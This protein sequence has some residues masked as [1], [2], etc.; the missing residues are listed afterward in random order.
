MVCR[1]V[2]IR[3]FLMLGMIG[4]LLALI[5]TYIG[6]LGVGAFLLGFFSFF[7]SNRFYIKVFFLLTNL[8]CVINLQVFE[9]EAHRV[10]FH[11]C[12]FLRP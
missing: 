10:I 5:G 11:D 2:V 12:N 4:F 7:F 8:L 1:C 6:I 9:S 3:V